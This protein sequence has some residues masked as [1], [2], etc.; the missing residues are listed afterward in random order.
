M[1]DFPARIQA[2]GG[3][4]YK[5]AEQGVEDLFA[6]MEAGLTALLALH[7]RGQNPIAAALALSD[8]FD[9]ARFALMVLTDGFDESVSDLLT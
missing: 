5:L 7:E 9:A 1:G 4:R 3:W 6:I 2:L 8:E